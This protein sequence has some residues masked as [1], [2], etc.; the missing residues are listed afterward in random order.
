MLAWYY[1]LIIAIL[2]LIGGLVLGFFEARYY[3]KKQLDKNP[4]IDEK[5]IRLILMQTGQKPSESR[6]RSIM[7][8][9]NKKKF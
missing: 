1:V 4:P 9:I 6:I 7:N 8:S 2:C 3:F 5:T